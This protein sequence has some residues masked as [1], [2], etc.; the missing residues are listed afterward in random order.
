MFLSSWGFS[1]LVF[2]QGGGFGPEKAMGFQAE[3][4]LA[5]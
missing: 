2:Q 4:A 3:T 1:K 5:T